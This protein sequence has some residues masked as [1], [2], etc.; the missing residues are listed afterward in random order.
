MNNSTSS[1]LESILLATVG[2]QTVA[3]SIYAVFL[4]VVVVLNALAAFSVYTAKSDHSA[5][6]RVYLLHLFVLNIAA[7]LII[8]PL[9]L[10]NILHTTSLTFGQCAFY[11]LSNWL[12]FAVM[13]HSHLL[14][15]INRLLAVI[16]PYFY[17]RSHSVRAAI[18]SCALT[19]M[20]VLLW[21]LPLFVYRMASHPVDCLLDIIDIPAAISRSVVTWEMMTFVAV[22]FLPVIGVMVLYPVIQWRRQAFLR[23]RPITDMLSQ[24]SGRSEGSGISHR[25]RA[26]STPDP[27]TFRVLMALTGS[28]ACFWLPSLIWELV[29]PLVQHSAAA[30]VFDTVNV[31]FDVLWLVQ[32][33][34]D[35]VLLI[36]AFRGSRRNLL[37]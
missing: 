26:V 6:F 4:V 30:Q 34:L 21:L 13:A 2:I 17:R 16:R 20:Y 27:R 15:T 18:S 12:L 14:I 22:L 25:R 10:L 37:R 1:H 28:L 23:V 19:W 24:D 9:D 29:Q 31:I 3:V 36:F 7:S 35:P 11:T 8:V 5:A 33:L 32:A